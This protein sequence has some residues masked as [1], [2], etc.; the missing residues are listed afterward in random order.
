MKTFAFNEKIQRGSPAFPIQI[1]HVT[2]AHPQYYMPLHWHREFEIIRVLSGHFTV[3][4]NNA[5]TRTRPGDIVLI[6]SGV[7]HHGVPED[8]VYECIVFDLNMLRKHHNDVASR[9]LLPLLAGDVGISR[10]LNS[11][12]TRLHALIDSL[13]DILQAQ[14]AYY[15]LTVFSLLFALFGELYS[16]TLLIPT[17]KT[18]KAGHQTE[19]IAGLIDW[20]ETHYAQ[21]VTLGELAERAGINDKYLCRLFREYTGCT[22]IDYLNRLRVEGACYEMAVN[23]RSVTE[24]AFDSGFND[25]SY[26]SRTFKKYKGM[27]PKEYRASAASGIHE[28]SFF[29]SKERKTVGEHPNLSLNSLEK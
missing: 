9:Y 23:G 15:E 5:E 8:C 7:L 25:L 22:P 24:A 12:D 11:G 14:T 10:V 29:V 16:E 28:L 19:V 17:P 3:H 27:T 4:L 20:M 26:F 21:P 18:K 6:S 2:E 1:Y 13:F